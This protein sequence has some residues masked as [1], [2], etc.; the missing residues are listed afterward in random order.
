MVN[1]LSLG[2]FAFKLIHFRFLCNLLNVEFRP[3]NVH[4]G[5]NEEDI[6]KF[7]EKAIEESKASEKKFWV[8]FDEINTCDCMGLFKEIICDRT[9]NGTQI[10]DNVI[11]F[12]ACNPYLIRKDAREQVGLV[13]QHQNLESDIEADM[14]NLVY[15][16]HPLPNSLIEYV[17]DYGELSGPEEEA[18]IRAMIHNRTSKSTPVDLFV[19]LLLTSHK[20]IRNLETSPI[21]V[22]S[23]RDV[24]RCIILFQWFHK[25]LQ[26]L[27][28]KAHEKTGSFYDPV[29]LGLPI[30]A[31]IHAIGI[32]YHARLIG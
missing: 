6:V 5:L 12:G 30:Q 11:S 27:G 21:L 23:L 7:M 20:F 16:V 17:W 13:Y 31:L 4:G 26:Q 22:V 24:E 32:A 19:K 28:K 9:L 2:I 25:F 15:R 8:F 14:K 18:Y 1:Q 10:P 3:L 29:H